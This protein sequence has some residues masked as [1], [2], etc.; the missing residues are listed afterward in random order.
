MAILVCSAD[1]NCTLHLDDF[2]R[3]GLVVIEAYA[4]PYLQQNAIC[5]KALN[6]DS[7]GNPMCS[8]TLSAV[9]PGTYAKPGFA[10]HA[11]LPHC[12]HPQSAQAAAAAAG[13]GPAAGQLAVMPSALRE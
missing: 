10:S 9:S 4:K 11:W 1:V 8:E 12:H 2:A 13:A 6:S 7:P 5:S 3:Q